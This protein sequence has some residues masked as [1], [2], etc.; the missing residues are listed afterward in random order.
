MKRQISSHSQAETL[1]IAQRLATYFLPGTVIALRGAL[2]AGKTTFVQGVASALGIAGPIIS[3]TFNLFKIYRGPKGSLF[4]FDCYRLEGQKADL[5][6][7]EYLDSEGVSFVEWPEFFPGT[8][9]R[10]ALTIRLSIEGE[11]ER[12]IEVDAPANWPGFKDAIFR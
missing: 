10:H 6:F 7:E 1:A 8:L 11:T 4:H 9:P 5:G 2:G 3:P 12:R